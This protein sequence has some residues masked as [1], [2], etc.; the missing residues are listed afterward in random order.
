MR[1]QLCT[2]IFGLLQIGRWVVCHQKYMSLRVIRLHLCI[3]QFVLI[4][5]IL[6]EPFVMLLSVTESCLSVQ[7][8]H[9]RWRVLPRRGQ[10][11]WCGCIVT[12]PWVPAPPS[13]LTAPSP[14]H[15]SASTATEMQSGSSW[16][17]LVKQIHTFFITGKCG[18]GGGGVI[19]DSSH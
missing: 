3:Y 8:T 18:E 17:L 13:Y 7:L 2:Y 5:L 4:R 11:V 16:R 12:L 6:A 9:R 14:K 15:S 19:V 1:E 10:G